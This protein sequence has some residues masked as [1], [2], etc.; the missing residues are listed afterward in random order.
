MAYCL[1]P[2]AAEE[3]KRR[4]KSGEL[5]PETLSAMTS[6]ERH[7]YFGSFVGEANAR[8]VNALFESKLLLKNQKAGIINWAKKT[9]GL[10]EPVRQD[11]IARVSRLEKVLAPAE[12]DAF[13]SDLAAK[14]LGTDVTREEGKKIIDLS[15]KVSELRT[16]AA[17]GE[18]ER[19]AFGNAVV[20]LKNYLDELNPNRVGKLQN[21][22]GFFR[23][24]KVIGDLGVPFR[25]GLGMISRPEWYKS[26]GSMFKYLVSKNAFKNLEADIVSRP[27][28]DAMQKG[29]LRISALASKLSQKEEDFMTTLVGKLPGLRGIERANVGF[30]TKLRADVFDNL[31]RSAEM[32]GENVKDVQVLKDLANVVN[33][34]TGSGNIGKDDRYANIVPALNNIFF[35]ARKISATMNIL[36][37]ANYIKVSPTARKAGLR[38][39]FGM[40]L[41]TATLLGLAKASGADIETDPKS[42]NFGKGVWGKMHVDF[43]GG[44]GTYAILLS[45]LISGQTKSSTSGKIYTLGTG[46]KPTTRADLLVTFFRNKLAPLAS[47]VANFLYGSNSIGEPFTATQAVKGLTVPMIIENTIDLVKNDP[48]HLLPGDLLDY[49]GNSV[50]VY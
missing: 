46:Y 25:Q 44:N 35:S 33:N 9:A 14:K 32:S 4:L 31:Y 6:A 28:Y 22:L 37:P 24:V 40:L 45:R 41:G 11:I 38:Q 21:I 23:S 8:E 36:N 7:A 20:D 29:G 2:Q 47:T 39:L 12:M 30:L 26:F 17:K 19:L 34:F 13:L 3:F 27:T 49:F 42:S 10:K 48:E 18:K 1:T 43:T 5:N 50:N 16:D 15:K